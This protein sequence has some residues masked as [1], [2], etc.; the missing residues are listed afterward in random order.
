MKGLKLVCVVGPKLPNK[1][2]GLGLEWVAEEKKELP[3]EDE[4]EEGTFWLGFEEKL[5]PGGWL[6]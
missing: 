1:E 5:N 2:F 4:L 6:K 3:N